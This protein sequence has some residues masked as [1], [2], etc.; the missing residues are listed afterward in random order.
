[1]RGFVPAAQEND[2]RVAN[3]REIDAVSRSVVD[4]YLA[5]A[6]ADRFDITGI[7]EFQATDACDDADAGMRV[8]KLAE[9][10]PEQGSL[11]NFDH[12]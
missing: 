1:L 11:A 4:A 8:P 12:L 3:T 2:D 9:P 10:F 7:A 5:D 6:T